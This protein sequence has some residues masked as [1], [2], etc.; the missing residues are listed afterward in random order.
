MRELREESDCGM[1]K[2]ESRSIRRNKDGDRRTPTSDIEP[3][4]IYSAIGWKGFGVKAKLLTRTK[5]QKTSPVSTSTDGE[6]HARGL[7]PRFLP[8]PC[9]LDL[10]NGEGVVRCVAR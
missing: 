4:N 6:R 5:T 3:E 7:T 9:V 10:Y 1:S 8:R 2:G